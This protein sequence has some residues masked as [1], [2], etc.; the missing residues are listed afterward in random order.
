MDSDETTPAAK[1]FQDQSLVLSGTREARDEAILWLSF[2]ETEGTV[3]FAVYDAKAKK[4]TYKFQGDSN[5]DVF[6][7]VKDVED[8]YGTKV[9]AEYAKSVQK[10]LDLRD[11]SL[12]L[13]LTLFEPTGS[14]GQCGD[15]RPD[16]LEAFY[17]PPLSSDAPASLGIDLS[18]GCFDRKT[19]TGQVRTIDDIAEAVDILEDAIDRAD[20][21]AAKDE[22]DDF[23]RNLVATLPENNACAGFG[24][25]K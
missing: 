19:F 5:E 13:S 8:S 7:F 15:N 25:G 16:S 20:T 24:G 4:Y 21:E 12:G 6:A 3:D 10:F 23:L 9:P 2:R 17:F 18:Y 11:K 22:I 1:Y 14:C